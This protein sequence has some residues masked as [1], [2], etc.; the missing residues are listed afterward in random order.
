[1]NNDYSG[2]FAGLS[3]DEVMQRRGGGAT[4]DVR[5]IPSKTYGRILTDN[6]LTLFNLVNTVLAIMVFSVGSYLNLLFFGMVIANTCIGIIQ[7]IRSKR[8]VEKL[9]LIVQ[10]LAL[11]IR[12]GHPQEISIGSIVIDDILILKAGGQIPAD[13]IVLA[14]DSLEVDESLLTGESRP[15]RKEK[16]DEVLSGSFVTSGS[17]CIQVSRVGKESYATQLTQEARRY[18]RSRSR[19]MAALNRIILVLSFV[20]VPLGAL[21]FYSQWAGGVPYAKAVVAT[22]AGII[23]IIP[24][25]LILLSTV[26]FAIGVIN[27]SKHKTLVQE[28]PSLEI[29][30]RVDVLCLDKTGT[31]TDGTMEVELID[32]QGNFDQGNIEQTISAL[33]SLSTDANPTQLAMKR[34]F[35]EGVP[36]GSAWEVRQVVPFSSGRRWQGALFAES[37][38]VLGAPEILCPEATEKVAEYAARGLR[39]L[40]LARVWGDFESRQ[41]SEG[42]GNEA[43]AL[44]GDGG[45]GGDGRDG[46]DGGASEIQLPEKRE[47]NALI[48]LSDTIRAQAPETFRFFAEQ[49]VAVKVISGD[50]PLTVAATACKAGLNGTDRYVDMSSPQE[51]L[52]GSPEEVDWGSLA[53]DYTVFGRVSPH[54]KKKL[55]Q[56]LRAN[57]HIVGM[58]GDGVNDVPALKEADCGIAMASGSEAARV[59]SELVL[60]ES[61]FAP[62]PAVV[63]EGCRVVNNIE[64]VAVLYLLKTVYSVLLCLFFI[65]LREPYPI[66]PIHLTLIGMTSI[67]VPSFFLALAANKNRV[68]GD[69]LKKTLNLAVPCGAL[70]VFDVLAIQALGV[71]WVWEPL[72]IRTLTVSVIGVVGLTVLANLCYPLRGKRFVLLVSMV[73]LFVAGY[74]GLS[75]LGGVEWPGVDLGLQDALHLPW[76]GLGIPVTIGLCVAAVLNVWVVGK[77]FWVRRYNMER[78]GKNE[79]NRKNIFIKKG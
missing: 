33:M 6:V 32:I 45:D 66:Y 78:F 39:V 57:G 44:G 11:V 76:W 60:L 40:A 41:G 38:W 35:G 36:S 14:G 22:A 16:G 3:Q 29:L 52:E 21:L 27:L 13:A 70:V 75:L 19:L 68:E 77:I 67:G 43:G 53:E 30:S 71:L 17:G 65:L 61:D 79:G 18:K 42:T 23:G 56:A 31:I 58:T 69:F 50:N 15:V 8:A 24:E 2:E 4:N 20:I 48:V 9:S 54:D 28:L 62:L 55:V 59:V 7:E 46:G 12:D 37:G 74:S 10:T 51:S 49:G 64:R 63:R 73:V 72:L 1:M 47:L 34:R 25:G 26:A 5:Q